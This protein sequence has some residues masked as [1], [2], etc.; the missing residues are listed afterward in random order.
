[1]K[2]HTA[3]A[4]E[5]LAISI[6]IDSRTKTAFVWPSHLNIRILRSLNDEV[7]DTTKMTKVEIAVQRRY[8]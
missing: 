7:K 2:Q 3:Y 1:M 5:V 8:S 6:K 4:V